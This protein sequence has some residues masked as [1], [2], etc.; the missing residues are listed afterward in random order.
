MANPIKIALDLETM[1]PDKTRVKI[2]KGTRYGGAIPNARALNMD[3]YAELVALGQVDETSF[4]HHDLNQTK[5]LLSEAIMNKMKLVDAPGGLVA[6]M[7]DKPGDDKWGEYKKSAIR[8][9]L[10]QNPFGGAPDTLRSAF[11]AP[12]TI[13]VYRSG[14]S[15]HENEYGQNLKNP[16][17]PG[18]I[19]H[20]SFHTPYGYDKVLNAKQYTHPRE[21][22]RYD[23][24][25]KHELNPE[26]FDKYEKQF[27][28]NIQSQGKEAQKRAQEIVSGMIYGEQI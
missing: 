10:F 24:S 15:G 22:D 6:Y 13:D 19:V 11:T 3:E 2:D 4:P 23:P 21:S 14:I 26:S 16:D 12:D 1:E 17:I 27:L 18:T 9:L 28:E 7:H 20:E 25:E 8:R 5:G